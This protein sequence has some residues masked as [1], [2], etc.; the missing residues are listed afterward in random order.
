MAFFCFDVE[1]L[2]IES[3]AICLS[4]GMV[5]CDP[6]VLPDDNDLAYQQM[7]NEG[8]F[9][10]FKAKEQAEIFKARTV[11]Q[12]VLTW[13]G[14][15]GD[16]QKKASFIPSKTDLGAVEGLEVLREWWS[17]FPNHK[18]LP[19]WIRGTLDQMILESLQRSFGVDNFVM[20]NCYR[21]VRTAIELLYPDTAKGGYVEIPDFDN[22]QVIK[23]HPTHDSAYDALMLIR[24][25][26]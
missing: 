2:G 11:D 17:S 23:H 8:L 12:D 4:L 22:Y 7:V 24:G 26:Q 13:W 25:K 6:T 3:T 14:K 1:T 10:K 5:H 9:V 20:Y 16:V 15:Q 18:N 19:V 21:D